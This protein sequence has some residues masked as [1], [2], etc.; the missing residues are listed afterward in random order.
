MLMVFDVCTDTPLHTLHSRS[1]RA[2][3]L[4]CQHGADHP[5]KHAELQPCDPASDAAP[6]GHVSP[7]P[8]GVGTQEKYILYKI[9]IVPQGLLV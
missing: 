5:E 4:Q 9:V 3:G 6:V 8:W 7:S 2:V 1:P